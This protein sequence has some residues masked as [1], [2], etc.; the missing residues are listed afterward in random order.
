MADE[1]FAGYPSATLY[2]LGSKTET[3]PPEKLKAHKQLLWGDT[4][5]VQSRSSDGRYYRVKIGANEGWVQAKQTQAK[6]L[7]EIV[8]VDIGQGDGALVVTPE[9]KRYVIDAG[10]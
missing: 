9:G 1:I 4:L 10:E 3:Q 8:Y 7:L 2:A 5:A 6:R